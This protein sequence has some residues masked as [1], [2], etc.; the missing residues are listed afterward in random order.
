MPIVIIFAR[1]VVFIFRSPLLL[2]NTPILHRKAKTATQLISTTEGKSG[3]DF[4]MC[5]IK[6]IKIRFV[7]RRATEA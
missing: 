3:F 6:E 2:A 1:L 5:K 7:S 4:Y